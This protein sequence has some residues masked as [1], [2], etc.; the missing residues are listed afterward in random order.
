[1][2]TDARG[3][4]V[5]AGSDAFD[6]QGSDVAASLSVNDFIMA[7]NATDRASKVTALAPT[8]GRPAFIFQTDTQVLWMHTGTT[9]LRLTSPR[10]YGRV[11]Q[12]AATAGAGSGVNYQIPWASLDTNSTHTSMWS[13]GSPTQLVIPVDGFYQI[14][15]S[16]GW[17]A[18][19]SGWR[20]LV[21]KVNGSSYIAEDNRTPIGA[22]QTMSTVSTAAWLTAG[23]YLEL[24]TWQNSGTTLGAS[25][26]AAPMFLTVSAA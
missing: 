2:S 9:G 8:T 7:A 24:Q 16:A 20:V 12:P 3:H 19:A 15:G 23:A 13:S 11:I 18:N 21:I 26:D 22:G 14:T 1:M 25:V 5:P 10:V 17:A 4:T 6:P